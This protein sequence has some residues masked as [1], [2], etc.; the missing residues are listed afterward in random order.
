MLNVSKTCKSRKDERGGKMFSVTIQEFAAL[1][2]TTVTAE[3]Q[4]ESWIAKEGSQ[5]LFATL[6]R[7]LP[8]V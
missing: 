2:A 8:Q 4:D 7:I 5:S 6:A 3:T 1:F